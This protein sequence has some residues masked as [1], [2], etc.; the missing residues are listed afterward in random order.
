MGGGGGSS[1]RG[2]ELPLAVVAFGQV[3]RSRGPVGVVHLIFKEVRVRV[4]VAIAIFVVTGGRSW[5]LSL[6]L[7]LWLG[8]CLLCCCGGG[9][10]GW[11]GML[12]FF[13][14]IIELTGHDVPVVLV[15]FV[16]RLGG[17]SVEGEGSWVSHWLWDVFYVFYVFYYDWCKYRALGVATVRGL[18]RFQ[19]IILF[20]CWF[21]GCGGVFGGAEN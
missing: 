3:P 19:R 9:G 11:S 7:W 12:V 13:G 15:V 20:Y 1:S 4:T 2:K 21:G 18:I 17:G 10:G 5:W 16:L 14:G 8:G 6:W